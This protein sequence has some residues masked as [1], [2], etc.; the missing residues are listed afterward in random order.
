LTDRIIMIGICIRVLTRKTRADVLIILIFPHIHKHDKPAHN[1]LILNAMKYG[2]RISLAVLCMLILACLTST[3]AAT[4]L[5]T[6]WK[7]YPYTESPFTRVFFS[8]NGS[9]VYAGGNQLLIRTWDGQ[10]RWGGQSGIIAT[11]SGDG[12]YVVNAVGDSVALREK[13]MAE[14]WTRYMNGQIKAVAISRNGTFV[15]SADDKDNYYSWS[16]YGSVL[17]VTRKNTVKKLAFSP[18]DDLVVATTIS[19]IEAFSPLMAPIWT[20]NRSSNGLDDAILFS[21]DGSTIITTGGNQLASHT[22][23]GK[24]NWVTNPT[25]NA[26]SGMACNY[27]CSL[28][29]IGSED[30]TVQAVDRYGKIRWTYQAGQ[31]VNA[32][33][34]SS[35]AS[36]I[37]AGG[38][39][40]TVYILDR[41]GKV[42]TMKKMDTGIRPQSL[43]VNKEGTR[44]V[45]ADQNY[46]YGL[47]VIGSTSPGIIEVITQEETIRQVRTTVTQITETPTPPTV[48]PVTT[49]TVAKTPVLPTPTRKSPVGVLPVLGALTGAGIVLAMRRE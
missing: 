16:N 31:W 10:K 12:E 36:I 40:G 15:I 43:A 41:A 9:L 5:G 4:S 32:V 26:I 2:F 24:L 7:D 39:D 49:E 30:G 42:T 34:V 47:T 28:V 45:V 13:T 21:D 25:T 48:I 35:D 14:R 1:T 23:A 44:I 29:I 3:A 46:L 33:G 27:D 11:M 19:G 18:K 6:E 8:E 38:L 37:A 22:R 17:G 20:D